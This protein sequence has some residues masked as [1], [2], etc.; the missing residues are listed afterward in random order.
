MPAKVSEIVHGDVEEKW[1]FWK[2]T[3]VYLIVGS[4][5]LFLIIVFR[6]FDTL[7]F[8]EV[9]HGNVSSDAAVGVFL[10]SFIAAL[11]YTEY[12]VKAEIKRQ[13]PKYTRRLYTSAAVLMLISSS[14]WVIANTAA[15][16]VLPVIYLSILGWILSFLLW[17]GGYSYLRW[18][19]KMREKRHAA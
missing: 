19:R 6:G 14:A 12:M 15:Y 2:R 7:G 11:E 5:V 3:N 13:Y 8:D 18:Y 17:A 10:L 9:G 1:A 4:L 16:V